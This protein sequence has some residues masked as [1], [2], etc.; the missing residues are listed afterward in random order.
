MQEISPTGAAHRLKQEPALLYEPG[1]SRELSSGLVTGFECM[2]LCEWLSS[3][4][5][6]GLVMLGLDGHRADSW[7]KWGTSR[8]G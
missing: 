6:A 8:A 7:A 5:K 1:L 2:Q 4:W 3:V